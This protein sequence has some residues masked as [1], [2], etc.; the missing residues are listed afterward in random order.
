MKGFKVGIKGG[1]MRARRLVVASMVAM[2]TLASAAPTNDFAGL[3]AP[4]RVELGRVES[5]KLEPHSLADKAEETKILKLIKNLAKIENPDFGLSPTF[6]GQAFA[7]I[8]SARKAEAFLITDHHVKE[9][10]DFA[11]LVKLGPRALPFLLKALDDQTPT[12][13]VVHH[14]GVMGRMWFANELRGN[15][16][17]DEEQKVLAT[18]PK[19]EFGDSLDSLSSYTVKIGDVCFVIIGQIVGRRYLTVR[20]QPTMCIVVNSPTHDAVMAGQVRAIWSSEDPAQHLLDSLLMDYASRGIFNGKSLDGWDVGSS[21][22]IEAAM[23]MLY[24]YPRETTNLIAARL[25][26]LDVRKLDMNGDVANGVRADEFVNAVAWS[27]EPAIREELQR[28]FQNTTDPKIMRDAAV[29]AKAL[30][31]T[32][33]LKRLED[34]LS[35]FPETEGGP[36][37]DGYELLVSLGTLFGDAAQPAFNRFMKNS[38][39]QRRRSMCRVLEKVQGKWSVEL[40]AP[41]LEDARPAEGWTY[42]VIPGQNEPRLPVRVCDEA[43]QTISQNFPKLTFKMAGKHDDLD[44]QIQKMREQIAHK[45]Y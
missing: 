7:P 43:A 22:Q 1:W 20:Y 2:A 13:L 9:S 24:Y 41:L 26:S 21:L 31:P 39:L 38:S 44:R 40:L 15:P 11:E 23:R 12:K 16:G 3:F 42:A 35:S 33:C 45:D 18:V 6:S 17:N 30:D 19:R 36:Y 28:I 27:E 32:A 10:N 4:A 5:I 8:A 14:E 29:S 34:F 25:R 37:G